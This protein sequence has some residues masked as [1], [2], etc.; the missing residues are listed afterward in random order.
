VKLNKVYLLPLLITACGESNGT[1]LCINSPLVGVWTKDGDTDE[2]L[3][4]E[5][6]CLGEATDSEA[7]FTFSNELDD[8]GFV[9]IV[10]DDSNGTG[11]LPNTGEVDCEYLVQNDTGLALNCEN[12]GTISYTRQE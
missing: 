5:E 1:T 12:A 6:S 10:V 7:S 3:T 11:T 9:E 8:E 2:T 4:F